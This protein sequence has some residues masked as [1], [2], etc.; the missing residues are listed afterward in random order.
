VIEREPLGDDPAEREADQVDAV[1]PVEHAE[2]I[3]DEGFDTGPG[4]V[5]ADDEPSAV[6]EPGA[7]V[8]LPREARVA[9]AVEEQE[10]GVGLHTVRVQT[11][12]TRPGDPEYSGD[13]RPEVAA[14]TRA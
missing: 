1:D 8:V 2:G 9:G 5:V 12:H 6:G 4:A 7:E 13:A 3:R 11:K 10:R 14:A